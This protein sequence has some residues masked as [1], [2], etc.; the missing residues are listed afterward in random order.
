MGLEGQILLVKR[1]M[2]TLPSLWYKLPGETQEKIIR[3]TFTGMKLLVLNFFY[4]FVSQK[5][6]LD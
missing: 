6:I 3:L 1:N 5:T 2:Q 4:I